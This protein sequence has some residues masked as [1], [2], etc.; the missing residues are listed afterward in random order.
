TLRLP[1]L[2]LKLLEGQTGQA[3]FDL[4]LMLKEEPEGLM[5]MLEYNT[6]IFESAT[7]ERL[8]AHFKQLLNAIIADPKQQLGL[9]NL[10]EANQ[11]EEILF[12]WN[13]TVTEFPAQ[14]SPVQLFEE[15][16]LRA[17]AARALLK[18]NETVTYAE[19]NERANQLARYLRDEG[20]GPEVIVAVYL[21][22]SV[23]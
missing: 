10:F 1:K 21:P 9:L 4:T 23:D 7:I 11:R 22:R 20:V 2:D 14:L 6:D 12:D 17:P 3:K 15:Q 8:L 13:E 18:G 5:G 16:V 19:L